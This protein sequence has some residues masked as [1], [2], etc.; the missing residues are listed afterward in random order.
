[1][2]LSGPTVPLSLETGSS[3]EAGNA[4]QL[5]VF[6]LQHLPLLCSDAQV[7][8]PLWPPMLPFI[9]LKAIKLVFLVL[10][11]I[12]Q[13]S[14]CIELDKVDQVRRGLPREPF[15]HFHCDMAAAHSGALVSL[16]TIL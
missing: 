1:M 15:Q 3:L 6:L 9:M 7:D 13:A 14:H 16:T 12:T 10:V 8:R 4:A 2:P 11:H 5:R